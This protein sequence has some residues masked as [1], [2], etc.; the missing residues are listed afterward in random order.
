MRKF[1]F[2]D[3]ILECGFRLEGKLLEAWTNADRTRADPGIWIFDPANGDRRRTGHPLR[4]TLPPFAFDKATE[5]TRSL[6]DSVG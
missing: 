6:K 2:K 5:T 3:G 1:A 4:F